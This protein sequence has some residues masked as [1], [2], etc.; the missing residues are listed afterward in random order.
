[1]AKSPA[2][3][4]DTL[5][6]PDPANEPLTLEQWAAARSRSDRQVELLNGFVAVQRAAGRF[7]ATDAEWRTLYAA[8]A[9]RPV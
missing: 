1:M 3:E 6:Q 7:T 4:P 9:A 8:F 5:P 2:E